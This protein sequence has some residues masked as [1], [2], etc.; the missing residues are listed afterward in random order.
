MDKWEQIFFA[1]M[2]AAFG[3]LLFTANKKVS[4]G[5]A[6]GNSVSVQT[7]SVAPWFLTYNQTAGFTGAINASGVT[8]SGIQMPQLAQLAGGQDDASAWQLF[9]KYAQV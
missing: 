9:P 3:W 6:V 8:G 1:V 4:G 2:L 5:N 7:G